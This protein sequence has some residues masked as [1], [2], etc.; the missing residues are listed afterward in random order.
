[1]NWITEHQIPIGAWAKTFVNWLTT[2]GEWFFDRLALILSYVIDALLYVLQAP[3]PLVVV[4]ALAGLSYWLHRSLG[5]ALFTGFGLLLIINQG[6]WEE[7]TETLA[8]VL[9]ASTVCM[10]IGVP[11]GILGARRAWIYAGM[12]PALDLMQT[13]PTL[14]LIHI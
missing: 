14:S 6:Y 12:R 8:L 7:T 2:S 11:L 1:M 9:A 10:L 13:I 3:H 5:N 4:A